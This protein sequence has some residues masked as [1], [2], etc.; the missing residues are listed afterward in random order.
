MPTTRAANPSLNLTDLSQRMG[1]IF[2]QAQ[3]SPASHQKNS[4]ALHGL[5]SNAARHKECL[6]EGGMGLTG[7]HAFQKLFFG[8]LLHVLPLK[9][10]IKP[11]DMI[12][13]FVGDFV[14]FIQRQRTC[15]KL[16]GYVYSR[17]LFDSA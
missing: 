14:G 7:E 11:A 12:A 6:P 16:A 4:I 17:L 15:L 13:K 3:E 5:L 9:K 1:Q 2:Q 10:S 8:N